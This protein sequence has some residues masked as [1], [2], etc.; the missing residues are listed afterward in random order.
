M[1]QAGERPPATNNGQLHSVAAQRKDRQGLRVQTCLQ[2]AVNHSMQMLM[3]Q[4][5]RMRRVSTDRRVLGCAG[6]AA[7]IHPPS[8]TR[9]WARCGALG[10]QTPL[11]L[12]LVSWWRPGSDALAG[13]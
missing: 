10:L 9:P 7:P 1:A 3:C 12:L 2:L 11:L 5:K 6:S 4:A 13:A 8:K